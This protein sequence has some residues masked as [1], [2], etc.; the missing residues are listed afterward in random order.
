MERDCAAEWVKYFKNRYVAE[1]QKKLRLQELERQGANRVDL[2]PK[3]E[4]RGEKTKGDIQ[5]ALEAK[6]RGG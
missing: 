4:L 5:S 6:R 3:F 2:E 1:L